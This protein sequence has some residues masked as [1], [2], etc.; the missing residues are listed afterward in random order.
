MNGAPRNDEEIL[1]ICFREPSIALGYVGSD[2]SRCSVK[3]ISK[4]VIPFWKLRGGSHNGFSEI[5]RP[6]VHFQFLE[7]EWHTGFI[8]SIKIFLKSLV[9]ESR[10]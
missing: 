1:S 10:D 9:L 5:H 3:L 4:E 7:E 2:R 8:A 6:L